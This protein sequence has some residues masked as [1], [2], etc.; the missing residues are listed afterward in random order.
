VLWFYGTRGKS[1]LLHKDACKKIWLKKVHHV[2]C[3]GISAMK[4]LHFYRAKTLQSAPG[5]LLLLTT[6][7]LVQHKRE[8]LS[9]LSQVVFS[10]PLLQEEDI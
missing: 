8:Q 10:I 4:V 9:A 3:N 7:K 5:N 2:N 1:I 6:V